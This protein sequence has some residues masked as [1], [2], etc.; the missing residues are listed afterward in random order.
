MVWAMRRQVGQRGTERRLGGKRKRWWISVA[1]VILLAAAIAISRPYN[2]QPPFRFILLHSGVEISDPWS[3]PLPR[4]TDEISI[5]YEFDGSFQ[6]IGEAL[7]KECFNGRN[8]PAIGADGHAYHIVLTPQ[9]GFET[10][11]GKAFKPSAKATCI[12][13]LHRDTSWLDR[14]WAA[15]RGWFG[16]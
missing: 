16:D 1:I 6:S 14:Q 8:S 13:E 2:H 5:F 4:S 9:R 11:F 7:K 12:L 15:V 3:F 10:R